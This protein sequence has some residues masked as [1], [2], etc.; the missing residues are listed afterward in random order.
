MNGRVGAC[1]AIS[2]NPLTATF[3]SPDPFVQNPESSTGYNRYGYCNYNPFRFTDPSGYSWLSKF[4]D[5][6]GPTGIKILTIAA[7]I[8]VAAVVTAAIIATGGAAALTLPPTAASL[9][10]VGNDNSRQIGTDKDRRGLA[11]M[12]GFLFI[13]N[14]PF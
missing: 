3:I 2:G 12:P 6:I 1:A 7:T 11:E 13:L 8:V 10:L 5:F 9:Q 14:L 4:G